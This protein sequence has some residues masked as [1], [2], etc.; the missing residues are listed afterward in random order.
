MH[1]AS[2]GIT[3]ESSDSAASANNSFFKIVPLDLV[4]KRH[5]WRDL[6]SQFA[7][8]TQKKKAP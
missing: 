5:D 6:V 4:L 1:P 2:A 3:V 7:I 8:I